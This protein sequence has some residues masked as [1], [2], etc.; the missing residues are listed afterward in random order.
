MPIDVSVVVPV[1]NAEPY[2]KECVDSLINQTLKNVE[3][4][5]V[6]DGSTDRSYEILQEY[7]QRDDRIQILRQQNLYAGVARNNGMKVA[8]GKY[9]IFLDADDFFELNMLEEAFDCAEKNE[10]QIT[11][12]RFFYYDNV[13]KQVSVGTHPDPPEEVIH[14]KQMGKK[15]FRMDIAAPW[16]KLY[17]RSFVSDN[18][19]QFQS[20]KKNNDVYFT[21]LATALADR[22]AFIRKPLIYYRINN[23]SSIQGNMSSGNSYFISSLILLRNEMAAR[24]RFD[25]T[26]R[27]AYNYY[28]V[29]SIERNAALIDRTNSKGLKDY[30]AS[31]KECLIPGL[32]IE[33]SDFSDSEFIKA[34]YKSEDYEEFLFVLLENERKKAF[35]LSKQLNKVFDKTVSKDS[36]DY[37]IGHFILAVPR[38]I[39]KRL[40]E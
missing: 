21:C 15:L 3:F 35:K 39:V 40:K 4:I 24:E 38:F 25:E 34:L 19:L 37:K 6:D 18:E 14:P 17:L 13:S 26:Y 8:I 7:Q 11:F 10:A 27:Q 2:L 12:F 16:T 32:F 33:P 36:K 9:I 30:F 28:T 22:I 31:I 20:I 5:F 1:Y 23:S 29:F